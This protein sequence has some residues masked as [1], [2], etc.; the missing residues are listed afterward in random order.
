MKNSR[1]ILKIDNESLK[2]AL[3]YQLERFLGETFKDIFIKAIDKEC[4]QIQ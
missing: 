1:I 4:Q 3:E 2:E